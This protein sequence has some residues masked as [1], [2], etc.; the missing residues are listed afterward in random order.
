MEEWCEYRVSRMGVL[1]RVLMVSAVAQPLIILLCL[2]MLTDIASTPEE[3]SAMLL[4]AV[5]AVWLPVTV[6]Y[7]AFTALLSFLVDGHT[8]FMLT[9]GGL[10]V[11][12]GVIKKICRLVAYESICRIRIR[13]LSDH[14]LL[15]L[16]FR[17]KAVFIDT[18]SHREPRAPIDEAVHPSSDQNAQWSKKG[19]GPWAI[20]LRYIQ[21]DLAQDLVHALVEHQEKNRL[22]R[23]AAKQAVRE[24]KAAQ[25]AQAVD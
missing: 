8:S 20:K 23:K 9:P 22:A 11:R 10:I 19:G 25:A 5:A 15:P 1:V 17:V 6:A 21:K 16:V 12:S 13:P 14:R 4:P 3:F 18:T 2:Y 24:K 7:V